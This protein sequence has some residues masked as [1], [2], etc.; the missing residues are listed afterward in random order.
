MGFQ[1]SMEANDT[2][3]SDY[4]CINCGEPVGK[5]KKLYCGSCA[6]AAQRKEM[7]MANLKIKEENKVKG[8]A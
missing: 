7:A 8:Y 5:T 1:G 4:R 3:K 6:T 2:L